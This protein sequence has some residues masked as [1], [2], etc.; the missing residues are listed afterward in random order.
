LATW[1]TLVPAEKT[2]EAVVAYLRS[3]R[4]VSL[5]AVEPTRIHVRRAA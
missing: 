1:K 5:T 2:E 4:T 3:S